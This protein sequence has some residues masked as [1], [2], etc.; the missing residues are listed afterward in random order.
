MS[1]VRSAILGPRSRP[2]EV[3]MS[4]LAAVLGATSAI[5]ASLLPAPLAAQ[6]VV[7]GRVVS[8]ADGMPVEDASV[9]VAG[10]DL[11]VGTDSAG[12]FRFEVPED[13]P[14]VALEIRVIGFTPF[15]R[16]WLLPLE[17]PLVIGLKREA[18]P[19]AGIDVDVDRPTGW[20]ARPLE[21]KLKF[22]V[23]SLMAIDRSATASDLR[24]FPH[25]EAELWDFLP[26]MNVFAFADGGF[27]ASGRVPSPA[28]VMDDRS[29]SFD[30]FRA[31]PVGE[32]CRLDVVTIPSPGPVK[33]GLVMAYSCQFLMDVA[34]GERML[35]PFL[36]I[37]LGGA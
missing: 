22:R 21:Y 11:L 15:N 1:P 8:A 31:Y 13:R 35:S 26:H 29:V 28:F 27:I 23:R 32:I 34:T 3:E 36:P 37:G 2:R 9:R 16:T 25:Q 30:E 5:L 19:L 18:I 7:E 4:R 33:G 24:E 10:E 14:G 20:T 12:Y 17:R 6:H